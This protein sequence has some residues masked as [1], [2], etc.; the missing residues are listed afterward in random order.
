ME[1]EKF[2]SVDPALNMAARDVVPFLYLLNTL[3]G[4]CEGLYLFAPSLDGLSAPT[5]EAVGPGSTTEVS[6][7]DVSLCFHADVG[8]GDMMVRRN[9]AQLATA[10]GQGGFHGFASLVN[11]MFPGISDSAFLALL[12]SLEV[13]RVAFTPANGGEYVS[14]LQPEQQ[15]VAGTVQTS[16]LAGDGAEQGTLPGPGASETGA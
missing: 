2:K 1:M 9:I 12:G 13:V 16:A 7:P 11:A 4:R 5:F 6:G 10:W 3:G 14:K 8:F 15:P